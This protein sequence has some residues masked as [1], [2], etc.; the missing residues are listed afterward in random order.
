MKYE[1]MIPAILYS[2]AKDFGK[3]LSRKGLDRSMAF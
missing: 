3:N 1:S 2:S